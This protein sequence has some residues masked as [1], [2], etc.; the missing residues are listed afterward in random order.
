MH[1]PGEPGK[2][3][4]RVEVLFATRQS[5]KNSVLGHGVCSFVIKLGITVSSMTTEKF[6]YPDGC[7]VCIGFFLTTRDAS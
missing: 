7:S 5:Q 4:F 6:L 2:E 1:R 3:S